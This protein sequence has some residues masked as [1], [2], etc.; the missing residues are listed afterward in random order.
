[1]TRLSTIP[2]TASAA[3]TEYTLPML[4]WRTLAMLAPEKGLAIS[5]TLAGIAIATV[6]LAEPILFGRVVDALAKR[7]QAFSIIALWAALGLFGIIANVVVAV[8]SDRL[9]HRR[10]LATLG[11]VF[12][13]AM[14]LPQHYHAQRGAGAVIRTV[15]AGTGS[16]FWLW[17]GAMREQMTAI[18][19]ILL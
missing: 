15:Q 17:L 19:G 4:Y 1:M 8:Y 12:E 13:R 16:L 9:A 6:Q 11:D 7:G 5:L 3:K 18:F 14:T 2:E 10:K